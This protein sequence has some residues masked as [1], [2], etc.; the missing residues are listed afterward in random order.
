M[1]EIA[2]IDCPTRLTDGV[3]ELADRYDGFLIDQW[4]VLHDGQRAYP[5]AVDCLWAIKALGKTVL[6]VSN[7]GKRGASNE[8]RLANMGF[9]RESYAEIVTS[10]DVAW[11]ALR[12]RPDASY[13]DLGRRCFLLSN[14]GDASTIEGL[15]LE[16]VDE[17]ARADFILVAGSATAN[18]A[19]AL[20]SLLDEALTRRLPLL[21][22]NPDMTR[23]V[24]GQL[25]P[26]SGA[27]A[28]RYEQLGGAVRYIGKPYPEI[29]RRCLQMLESRGARRVV[30]VGDS[31]D[32]DIAGAAGVGLDTVLVT[33]GILRDR[34]EGRCGARA[35]RGQLAEVVRE[36]KAD[37]PTWMMPSLRWSHDTKEQTRP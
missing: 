9:P 16:A 3:S 5:G 11:D 24:D 25:V 13:H 15:A 18:A 22:V 35:M 28:R 26:G 32:H 21:C 19:G 29:Y 20:G 31:L 14:D 37:W 27:L 33:D 8:T 4:G 7:S 17:I 34:F 23:F 36:L 10:G 12:T 30:A 2:E 6:I 1:D